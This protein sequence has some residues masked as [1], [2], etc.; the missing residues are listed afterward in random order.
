MDATDRVILRALQLDG[1]T[2]N[3]D[4][5]RLAGLSEAQC[6]RRVRNLFS[7]GAIQRCVAVLDAEKVGLFFEADVFVKLVTHDARA[8]EAWER[9]A[10]RLRRVTEVSRLTGRFDYRLRYVTESV[11][12][13][14]GLLE[15]Q[16]STTTNVRRFEVMLVLK[17]YWFPHELDGD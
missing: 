8:L 3:R 4:L 16:L 17:T 12:Q 9:D 11:Q 14:R 5:A 2:P 7:S 6:S 15:T 1:R 13:F 10:A